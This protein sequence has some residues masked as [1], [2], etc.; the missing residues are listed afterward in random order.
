MYGQVMEVT[1]KYGRILF[2][3]RD[4]TTLSPL[5]EAIFHNAYTGEPVETGSRGVVVLFEV[6]I[7]PKVN[8][9]LGSHGMEAASATTKKLSSADINSKTLVLVM[10]QSEKDTLV[11]EYPDADIEVLS[12]LVNEEE[13]FDP[14]G[15]TLMDYEKAFGQLSIIIKKLIITLESNL[16]F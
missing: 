9:V 5:A 3:C 8:V 10:Y 11:K 1:M 13:I 4:N 14:Y 2:V 16:L 7:N 12:R 15:G 6:P